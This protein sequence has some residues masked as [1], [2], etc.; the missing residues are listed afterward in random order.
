MDKTPDWIK[1]I[2]ERMPLVGFSTPADLSRALKKKNHTTV[3][4]WFTRKPKNPPIRELENLAQVLNCFPE[5]IL[6]GKLLPQNTTELSRL[7]SM[8]GRKDQFIVNSFIQLVAMESSLLSDK[9]LTSLK[10]HKNWYIVID[11]DQNKKIMP[12]TG[13]TKKPKKKADINV[14]I[15]FT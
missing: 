4:N 12:V 14:Q 3:S 13:K 11:K 5:E 10:Q 8:M 15:F 7:I 6:A 2:K 9:S 1:F